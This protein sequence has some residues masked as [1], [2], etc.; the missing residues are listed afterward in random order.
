MTRIAFKMKLLKGYE[1]E[2]RR[3]HDALWPGLK[4]LL[5]QTGISGYSIFFDEQTLDLVGI[6]SVEDETR[7]SDLPQHPVMQRW[8][9]YMEDIMETNPDHSPKQV[10]LKEVFYLE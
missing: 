5:K 7:L 2:Y 3:R 4:D 8:W 10:A 1:D 9:K 6:L